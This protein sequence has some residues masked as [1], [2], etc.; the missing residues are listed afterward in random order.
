MRDFFAENEKTALAFSGGVDSSYLLYAAA[1]AGADV[2][3]Y[4]VN[5]AFQPEFEREMAMRLAEQV[6]ELT[7][8]DVTPVVIRLDVLSDE[9]VRSNPPDRCYYCKQHIMGE[10]R[11]RAEAD[12][13]PVLMDGTNAS[14]DV[15]DRPGM[16]ALTE[17][18]VVSP[19]RL[20]GLT[21]ERIRLLSREA[22]L[23]TWDRPSYSC[24]ATRIACG[25]EITPE[26]LEATERAE[27]V[28]FRMGFP[29]VRVRMSAGK[30]LIEIPESFLGLYRENEEVIRKKL[31]PYYE[32]IRLSEK[33]RP[34]TVIPA[35]TGERL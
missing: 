6:R 13:Y 12:G 7:G 4:Y 3:A 35:E 23:F 22:G 27:A 1:E 34:E 25:E 24:L 17:Y 2:K 26:K 8:R 18:G 15:A 31:S 32:E 19:L 29:D 28:L 10:I 30:A 11:R 33:R 16:K 9:T 20:C 5:A 14:D 21:K